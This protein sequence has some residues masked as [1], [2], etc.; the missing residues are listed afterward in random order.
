M[1]KYSQEEIMKWQEAAISFVEREK[2]W[3]REDFTIS[4]RTTKEEY[5]LAIFSAS[6]KESILAKEKEI[7][8]TGTLSRLGPGPMDLDIFVDIVDLS[9]CEVTKE[10]FD[11]LRE[12][13][14]K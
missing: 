3:K 14:R 2:G 12:K 10:N 5:K 1:P 6:H 9:A 11:L 8:E 13:H 4:F 7:R